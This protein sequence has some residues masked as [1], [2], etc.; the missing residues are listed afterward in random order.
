MGGFGNE[1]LGPFWGGPR[2]T[3]LTL[4]APRAGDSIVFYYLLLL[5][6]LAGLSKSSYNAPLGR[7][8]NFN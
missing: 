4:A 7:C 6:S 3:T 5:K 8:I 2:N 1:G